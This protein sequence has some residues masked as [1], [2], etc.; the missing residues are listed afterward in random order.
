MHSHRIAW[1]SLLSTMLLLP[2]LVFAMPTAQAHDH[3]TSSVPAAGATVDSPAQV[4]LTFSGS[5]VSAGTAVRV[6]G[7]QG[8][9]V[10]G[11]AVNVAGPKVTQPLR[12]GLAAGAYTVTW[13]VTSADGHPVSGTFAFTVAR[14]ATANP[15]TPSKPGITRSTQAAPTSATSTSP[16]PPAKQTP[17]NSTNNKPVLIGTAA[18]VALLLIGAGAAYARG[19]LRDDAPNDPE[20]GRN[21]HDSDSGP[22]D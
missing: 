16:T 15:P 12:A 22:T 14:N 1:R 20:N 13:R 9:D 21:G 2:L 7:P 18:V 3:L 5:V 19:R 8:A 17:T 11:G 6:V 10:T 4:S